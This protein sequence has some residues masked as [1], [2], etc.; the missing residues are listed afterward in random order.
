MTKTGKRVDAL[1][2]ARFGVVVEN[3]MLAEFVEASGLEAEVE[4]FEYQEG[5]NNMFTYKLPGRIKFPNV[6]LKRGMTESNDLWEWFQNVMY[7][8]PSTGG[9]KDR[10][11]LSI[12][13]KNLS[14]VLYDQ[15]FKE[16]RRW[17]LINAYPV[18]WTGPSFKADSNAVSIE[19]LV[20]AH[21]GM[22]PD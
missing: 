22:L 15:E 2:S 10:K 9:G 17:N 3:V 13:R 12:E 8:K 16:C 11:K 18:K 20:L 6:I 1:P 4:T 5:G 21:E 7:Q 19:T 14:I